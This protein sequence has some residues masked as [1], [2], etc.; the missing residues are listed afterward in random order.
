MNR[1]GCTCQGA[2]CE[3]GKRLFRDVEHIYLLLTGQVRSE[4]VPMTQEQQWL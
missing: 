3:D 1:C 2:A 4:L